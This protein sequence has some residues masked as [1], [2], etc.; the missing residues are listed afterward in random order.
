[1]VQDWITFEL[2]VRLHNVKGFL[3]ISEKAMRKLRLARV[4]L[5][6][7]TT[8]VFLTFSFAVIASA[9]KQEDGRTFPNYNCQ[10]FN[11]L[12]YLSLAQVILMMILVVWLFVES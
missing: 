7:I 9:H 3:D 10:L 6:A 5:F 1:M 4:I 8:L 11:V 12:G 2:A